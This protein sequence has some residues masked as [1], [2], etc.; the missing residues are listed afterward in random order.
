MSGTQGVARRQAYV[1]PYNIAMIS[2]T[3]TAYSWAVGQR[4]LRVRGGD[5]TVGVA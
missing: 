4:L 5:L 3:S 1:G 2:S